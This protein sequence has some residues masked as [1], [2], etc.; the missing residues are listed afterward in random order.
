MTLT[1]ARKTRLLELLDNER[2]KTN[3]SKVGYRDPPKLRELALDT[4]KTAPAEYWGPSISHAST[5][6]PSR[7]STSALDRTR[8]RSTANPMYHSANG[9][10]H[11]S[12]FKPSFEQQHRAGMAKTQRELHSNSE[13]ALLNTLEVKMYND[14]RDVVV[15]ERKKVSDEQR[16]YLD[17]Q[18]REKEYTVAQTK[19]EKERERELLRMQLERYKEDEARKAEE[20]LQYRVRLNEDRESQLQ[21]ARAAQ[22]RAREKKAR[23]D[24]RLAT[25]L[26]TQA[27]HEK[28]EKLRKMEEAKQ[29]AAIAQQENLQRIAARKEAQ[30]LKRL[31]E[32]E[33]MQQT[34]RTLEQ[35]EKDR[36]DRLK[37]FYAN[38]HKRA[39]N[40]GQIVVQDRKDR[41]EREARLIKQYENRAA[42]EA[43]DREREAARKK[44][45]FKAEILKSRAESLAKANESKAAKQAESAR[46]RAE[47]EARAEQERQ[48][49]ADKLAVARQ[50]NLEHKRQL[51]LQM[52]LEEARRVQDDIM[53]SEIERKLNRPLL[54]QAV[55]TVGVP[56]P[57]PVKFL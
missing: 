39:E 23:E 32:E 55:Q 19:A 9:N 15:R 28:A 8:S 54:Q 31:E 41:E 18:V 12:V 43:A 13:W 4:H 53:M 35:Q 2:Q 45:K 27:E 24:E 37:E 33:L 7:R 48:R 1:D 56:H 44:E 26:K 42:K 51:E 21:D 36:E 25:Q 17:G 6:V 30:R 14:E 52:Q 11:S 49:E 3:N 47:L 46:I 5:Y 20:L 10:L 57:I 40:V 16:K 50:K 22:E 34:L 38:I 29:R